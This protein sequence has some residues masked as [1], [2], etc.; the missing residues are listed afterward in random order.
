MIDAVST[1][2]KCKGINYP[3]KVPPRAQQP[4]PKPKVEKKPQT[5]M[6]KEPEV[7]ALDKVQSDE[8]DEDLV[9]RAQG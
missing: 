5:L 2:Y 7:E 1:F 8:S 9:P 3:K 6:K 4:Q